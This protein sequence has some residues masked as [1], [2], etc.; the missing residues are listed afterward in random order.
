MNLPRLLTSS[1]YQASIFLTVLL[2]VVLYFRVSDEKATREEKEEATVA[3]IIA[4]AGAWGVSI[5]ATGLEDYAAKRD[6]PAKPSIQVNTGGTN[7]QNPPQG[8]AGLPV[9]HPGPPPGSG[10]ATT[11][12]STTGAVASWSFPAGVPVHKAH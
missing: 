8:G 11:A 6:A 7:T 3:Y 2:S 12:G 10:F 4:V 5:G 9:V 1:K